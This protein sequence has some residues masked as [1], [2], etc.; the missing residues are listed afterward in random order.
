MPATL[1]LTPVQSARRVG[2]Y[3]APEKLG[4]PKF[5]CAR[6]RAG[7]TVRDRRHTHSAHV[8]PRQVASTNFKTD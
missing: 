6:L 1:N 7:G 2:K 3:I 4:R 8:S 5:S